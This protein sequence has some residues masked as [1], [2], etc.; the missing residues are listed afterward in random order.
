MRPSP[1][2]QLPGSPQPPRR[3]TARRLSVLVF[4][5]A[6][7]HFIQRLRQASQVVVVVEVSEDATRV[8]HAAAAVAA[9]APPQ[10][11]VLYI[12]TSLA[13]TESGKRATKQGDDRWGQTIVPVIRETT[14]SLALTYGNSRVDVYLICHYTVN[15]TRRAALRQALPATVGLRMWDDATPLGY[16]SEEKNTAAALRHLVPVTRGLARQ[17]RYVIK[18]HLE[19]YD[20]FVNFE[21]DML[22]HGAQVQAYNAL[23]QE[24]Y[25]L[26]QRAPRT[27]PVATAGSSASSQVH[28]PLERFYGPLTQVMLSRMLPGWMRVEHITSGISPGTQPGDQIP[29]TLN[30]PPASTTTTTLS[31]WL[32]PAQ[33][34]TATATLDPAHCCGIRETTVHMPVLVPPLSQLYLWETNLAAL[35]LREMPARPK[36][37]NHT[38]EDNG[39][40]WVVLLTGND[41]QY[42]TD[43][44]L[45]IGDYWTGREGA[46]GGNGTTAR[47]NRQ[48]GDFMNNQG[49]WMATRRQ[50]LEWHRLWC[51][52]SLLPPYE[53][54][55]F[56][57]DGLAKETVEF[58]SGGF[59]L[60]GLRACNLQRLIPLD[61][62]R[63]GQFL[64]YHTSN[65]KQRQKFV[66]HR[67]YGRPI[68]DFWG[69]LNTV[70]HN[71]EQQ[72]AKETAA[73]G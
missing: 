3:R 48:L 26:R 44:N 16:A 56:L 51:R 17:H 30:W 15:A 50:I 38:M 36:N 19:D 61:P 43:T 6:L 59:Q 66:K 53:A 2:S 68:L 58:W 69:Q 10:P 27:L 46:F 37:S 47:P 20:V 13:D 60:A 55:V 39:I 5:W 42:M 64:L 71:A 40:G 24:L 49:G 11:R 73:A 28:N 25:Q 12:V 7:G 18:D 32:R 9:A 35:G 34:T 23:T 31:S 63:F 52:G 67:F 4:L 1:P 22:L 70:R 45:Q 41:E 72:K 33:T 14:A 62:A 21:D 8:H 65:N 29:V 54:P 57:Q